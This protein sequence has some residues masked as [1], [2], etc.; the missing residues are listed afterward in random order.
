MYRICLETLSCLSEVLLTPPNPSLFI[1]AALQSDAVLAPGCRP[2]H[3]EH[4]ILGYFSPPCLPMV[5]SPP[6]SA[7]AHARIELGPRP[8]CQALLDL[9]SDPPS[10]ALTI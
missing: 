7:Y 9:D 2:H 10:S 8:R 6:G 4:A 3:P 1:S 5:S